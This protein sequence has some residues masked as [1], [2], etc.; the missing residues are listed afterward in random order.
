MGTKQSMTTTQIATRCIREI[1]GSTSSKMLSI[2][3]RYYRL[4]YDYM[5]RKRVQAKIISTID[6]IV[7]KAYKRKKREFL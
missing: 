3:Y 4:F 7:I 6:E 2:A 5:V 1:K